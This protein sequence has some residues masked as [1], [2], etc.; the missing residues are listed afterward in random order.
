M[1]LFL[2]NGG[3]HLFGGFSAGHGLRDDQPAGFHTNLGQLHAE[4]PGSGYGGDAAQGY[5]HGSA[6]TVGERAAEQGSDRRHA[7]E[8]HGIEG[9]D[10][11]AQLVGHHDLDERVRRRHLQ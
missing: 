5:G 6:E 4:P 2:D 3:G 9:H 1:N 8:H 7:H 11:A 10:A